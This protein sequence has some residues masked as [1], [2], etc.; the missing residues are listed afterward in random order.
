MLLNRVKAHTA[1]TGTGTVTLGTAVSPYQSF[2]AGGA[3]DGA[4]ISYLIEDGTA[5]ELGRGVYSAGAGT[6][7]RPGPGM[8]TTFESSTGAL[9]ALTG[10]ATIAC[11]ASKSDFSSG[12]GGGGR[13]LLQTVHVTSP[14][15][16]VNL[17]LFD[18]TTYFH[19]EIEISGATDGLDVQFSQDG[20]TTY[21]GSSIYDYSH[22][23]WGTGGYNQ[24]YQSENGPALNLVGGGGSYPT[25]TSLTLKVYDPANTSTHKN[26]GLSGFFAA[27]DGRGYTMIGGGRYKS[28]GAV[29]A[30]RFVPDGVS[31]ISA[32]TFRLFGIPI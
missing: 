14:V 22:Q 11:A 29:N 4:T 19:Y 31:T 30:M 1:T 13:V 12:G 18:N 20:G 23:V 27:G 17:T 32:G 25:S 10:S 9:L 6:I 2:S 3:T 26:V 5:W 24:G 28:T 8:D 16:D 7:T 21:D 15:S